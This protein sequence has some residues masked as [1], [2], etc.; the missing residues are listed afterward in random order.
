MKNVNN[1]SI[2][3][4]TAIPFWG[5]YESMASN[6]IEHGIEMDMEELEPFLPDD[7]DFWYYSHDFE[8]CQ[9][10]YCKQYVDYVSQEINIPLKFKVLSSPREYNFTTDRVFA[11][12]SLENV[13]KL[14]NE[15]DMDKLE[16]YITSHFTSRDG[17]VSFYSND[18]EYWKEMFKR[19]LKGDLEDF[20]HNHICSLLDVTYDFDCRDDIDFW[21]CIQGGFYE[22]YVGNNGGIMDYVNKDCQVILDKAWSRYN[23][24]QG[25]V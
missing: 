16:A 15:V 21:D 4:E 7:F 17:F 25:T 9:E 12:I 23:T 6:A 8:E 10:D 13:Q 5:F 14:I 19:V 22:E 18:I 3:L 11:E 24:S 2:T 1:N 20:D